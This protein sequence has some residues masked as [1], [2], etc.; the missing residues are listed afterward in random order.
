MS[1]VC[2]PVLTRHLSVV[3]GVTTFQILRWLN[4]GLIPAPNLPAPSHSHY[5]WSHG[6]LAAWSPAIADA[7]HAIAQLKPLKLPSRQRKTSHT[8]AA[9]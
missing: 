6:H 9:A 4:A 8:Q 3:C 5:A 7:A 2:H 1:E